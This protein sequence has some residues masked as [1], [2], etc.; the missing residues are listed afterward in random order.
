MRTRSEPLSRTYA[1]R[2]WSRCSWPPMY[3][4]GGHCSPP[5]DRRAR[6]VIAPR[7]GT[8]DAGGMA[9]R[10]DA[11][12]AAST[13]VLHGRGPELDTIR[14]LIDAARAGSGG[15][16]VVEGEPGAGKSALLE[17]A[18]AHAAGFQ[19]LRARGIQSEAELAFAGL[20]ELLAPL[21]EL[22][23][24]LSPEQHRTLRTALDARGTAPA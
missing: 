21:A 5:F 23:E 17:A 10:G 13:T 19:V 24:G 22:A 4:T 3:E 9:A 12:P 14:T 18:A 1:A 16:L 11:R 2:R 6:S 20:T 7:A 15:V 8:D